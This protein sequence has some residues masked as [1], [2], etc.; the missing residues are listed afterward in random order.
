MS[1]ISVKKAI[2][3]IQRELNKSQGHQSYYYSWQSSIACCVMDNTNATH[4]EA[5]AAA[6]AFL[7]LLT[8]EK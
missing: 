8:D 1:A 7:K 3:R 4:E 2:E 5:N 6:K